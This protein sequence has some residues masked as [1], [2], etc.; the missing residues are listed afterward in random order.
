MVKRKVRNTPSVLLAA[1]VEEGQVSRKGKVLD[2]SQ[3][4]G[5]KNTVN[6]SGQ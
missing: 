2:E 4:L 5:Q 1:G 6:R 3:E